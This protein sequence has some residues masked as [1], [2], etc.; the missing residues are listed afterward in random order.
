MSFSHH[1][2]IP[3]LKFWIPSW[4][5][6]LLNWMSKSV[7]WIL[8]KSHH[9]HAT[10]YHKLQVSM[11]EVH[12]SLFIWCPLVTLANCKTMCLTSLRKHQ[13]MPFL[14]INTCM[15]LSEGEGS[16][17]LLLS[18]PWTTAPTV[19]IRYHGFWHGFLTHTQ[20][21]SPRLFLLQL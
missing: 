21:P 14:S 20:P 19:I 2:S 8:L 10:Y 9:I 12:F 1:R 5:F 3:N 6:P 18:T 15:G 17:R 11:T 16:P 13:E 4:C 7:P